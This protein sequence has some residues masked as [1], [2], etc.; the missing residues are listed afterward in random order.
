ME[1]ISIQKYTDQ[2][3]RQ[4]VIFAACIG[5]SEE[6]FSRGDKSDSMELCKKSG[7]D[8]NRKI[9]TRANCEMHCPRTKNVVEKMAW[10]FKNMGWVWYL[11][12][13]RFSNNLKAQK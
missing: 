12:N 1:M 9:P 6:L 3:A 7:D 5:F 2:P 10:D 11:R 8:F 13:G 4:E